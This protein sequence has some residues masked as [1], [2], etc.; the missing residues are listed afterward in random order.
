MIQI[1]IE[2]TNL[3]PFETLAAFQT[4]T[5]FNPS[6]SGANALFIGTMRDFN[7][8]D[9]VVGMRLEHYPAMTEKQLQQIA[10]AAQEKWSLNHVLISHRIGQI[11]PAD[12]IVLVATWSVHRNAAFESCRHIMEVLKHEAPFWK[13]ET[14][15]DGS[16][17]WVEKNT[18]G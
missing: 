3:A 2:A 11:Q 8:G 14:L 1:Q 9:D 15:K 17:R 7:E 10:Q 16:E 18:A 12:P 4:S 5:D 6:Q 13:H